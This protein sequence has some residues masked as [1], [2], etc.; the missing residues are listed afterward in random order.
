[1]ECTRQA[2]TFDYTETHHQ[3]GHY[4][5]IN[6]GITRGPGSGAPCNLNN[7]RHSKAVEDLLSNTHMC[8][9]ATYASGG[10]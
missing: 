9:L 8:R 7:G 6:T 1:M 2:E 5:V 4:A 3:R 10:A